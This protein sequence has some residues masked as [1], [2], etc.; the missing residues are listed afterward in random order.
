MILSFRALKKVKLYKTRD[1]LQMAVARH[2]DL[3]EGRFGP[4]GNAKAVHGNEHQWVS[5]S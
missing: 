2:P 4:L 5:S 3:L 1:F